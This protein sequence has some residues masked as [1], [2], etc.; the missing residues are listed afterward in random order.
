MSTMTT[1]KALVERAR[2]AD[3]DVLVAVARTEPPHSAARECARALVDL[4]Y[5]VPELLAEIERLQGLAFEAVRIGLDWM[6][7]ANVE[8]NEEADAINR[9]EKR[10]LAIRAQVERS[11]K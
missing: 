11:G 8:G 4:S 3:E 9:D 7:I 5:L 1:A 6:R 10:L 2:V